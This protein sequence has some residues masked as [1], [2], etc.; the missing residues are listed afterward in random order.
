MKR[1]LLLSAVILSLGACEKPDDGITR[2]QCG[3]YLTEMTF[4]DDGEKMYAVINGDKLTLTN[5]VSAS[6]AK[7]VGTLNDTSVVLWSKGENW[8]MILDDDMVI[9]CK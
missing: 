4:S 5:D 7:F 9:E 3:D 6:G 8:I 1:I 2:R